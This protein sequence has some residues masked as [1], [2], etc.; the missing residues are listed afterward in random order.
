[1]SAYLQIH[2]QIYRIPAGRS[3]CG[4]FRTSPQ[5]HRYPKY[6]LALLLFLENASGNG[7]ATFI[8]AIQHTL[9][10]RGSQT[11]RSV[12][13]SYVEIGSASDLAG[14]IAVERG[15]RRPIAGG[16]KLAA[17]QCQQ[18]LEKDCVRPALVILMPFKGFLLR[19]DS[20]TRAIRYD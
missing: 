7:A 11:A 12:Q 4:V 8:E 13:M 19:Y 3:G 17:P 2:R 10:I 15:P 18:L 5:A 16:G 1:M 14:I 20:H 9:I 6:A